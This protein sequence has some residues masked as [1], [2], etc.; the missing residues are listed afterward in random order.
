MHRFS[1]LVI[2][3]G[4]QQSIQRPVA[5]LVLGRGSKHFAGPTMKVCLLP[6]IV[7]QL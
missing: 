3:L 7:I 4:R 5:A 6:K 1:R 2:S